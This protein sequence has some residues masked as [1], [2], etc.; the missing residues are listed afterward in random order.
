MVVQGA[1]ITII[2]L[3][4]IGVFKTV[5]KVGTVD[6]FRRQISQRIVR[7]KYILN[8][9]ILRGTGVELK[10]VCVHMDSVMK[11]KSL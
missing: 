9:P 10:A 1:A 5:I 4:M 2:S 6:A 8:A 7:K 3:K 11:K